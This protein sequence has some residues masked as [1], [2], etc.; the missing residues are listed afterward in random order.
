M[1]SSQSGLAHRATP[2]PTRCARAACALLPGNCTLRHPLPHTPLPHP[3]CVL[4][5]P[6]VALNLAQLVARASQ[7]RFSRKK[8]STVVPQCMMAFEKTVAEWH[9][10]PGSEGAWGGWVWGEAGAV[11]SRDQAR[12]SLG[13]EDH[14][15]A[16]HLLRF[17]T[18][19]L[20]FFRICRSAWLWRAKNWRSSSMGTSPDSTVLKCAWRSA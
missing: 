2:S 14:A 1:A 17:S 10:L 5:T 16:A 13:G 20:M 8:V 6:A 12:P 19:A 3:V 15:R 18:V 9:T 7:S 4:L 11:N